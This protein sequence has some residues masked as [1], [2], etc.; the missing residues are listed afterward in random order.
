[1]ARATPGRCHE[2]SEAQRL[3]PVPS[4][5]RPLYEPHRVGPRAADGRGQD[6]NTRGRHSEE[7]VGG[8][9]L[10]APGRVAGEPLGEGSPDPIKLGG[11]TRERDHGSVEGVMHRIQVDDIESPQD[12]PVQEDRAHPLERPG[13]P[14]DRDHAPGGI[15]PVHP[16]MVGADRLDVIWGG[17]DH[18]RDRRGPVGPGERAVVHRDDARMGLAQGTP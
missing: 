15:A 12:R 18:R 4:S 7:P 10:P 16:H 1:M 17:Q 13:G 6:G 8:Q 11:T 9:E 14:H 2:V 3:G 5:G